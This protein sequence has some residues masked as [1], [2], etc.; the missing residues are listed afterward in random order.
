[1]HRPIR[2]WPKVQRFLEAPH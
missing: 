1:M 2:P